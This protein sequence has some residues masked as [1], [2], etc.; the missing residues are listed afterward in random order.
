MD[1]GL[2]VALAQGAL[3]LQIDADFPDLVFGQ[4]FIQKMSIGVPTFGV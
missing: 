4:D 3:L 2:E 1:H